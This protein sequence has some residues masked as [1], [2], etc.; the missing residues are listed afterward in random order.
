[1]VEA[2]LVE[3]AAGLLEEPAPEAAEL[4]AQVRGCDQSPVFDAVKRRKTNH[5]P[6][7]TE[8]AA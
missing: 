4:V 2:E 6:K 1:M 7:R 8:K 3:F 5:N